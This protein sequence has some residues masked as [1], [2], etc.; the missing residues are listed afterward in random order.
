MKRCGNPTLQQRELLK[1]LMAE[2]STH[3]IDDALKD[4]L[5]NAG[6]VV[7]YSRGESII[8]AGEL[9]S[10]V[11][12]IID[13][14][15]RKWYWEGK[16]EKTTGLALPGTLFMS[17]HGYQMGEPGNENYE[18]CCATRLIKISRADFDKLL[19][20]SHDFALW[21]LRCA[22]MD[23]YFLEIKQNVIQGSARERFEALA[24]NYP[25]IIKN[26]LLKVIA[27]YLG[28]SPQHLSV[29]R[30]EMKIRQETGAASET[31]QEN[32]D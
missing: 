8:S 32:K 28:I 16:V 5:I 26:V 19:D 15:V 6:T 27:S 2:E 14:I 10:S 20:D 23:L 1:S 4:R 13:G 3:P 31:R 12:I 29:L 22:Y 18:A 11:F 21:C 25:I 17:V 7:E 9:C 24:T 30:R